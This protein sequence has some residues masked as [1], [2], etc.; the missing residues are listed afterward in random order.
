M[1]W[2]SRRSKS[3]VER[4]R[5]DWR[6][7]DEGGITRE[8]EGMVLSYSRKEKCWLTEYKKKIPTATREVLVKI[9]IGTYEKLTRNLPEM[10]ETQSGDWDKEFNTALRQLNQ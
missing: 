1:V 8:S 9:S 4:R 10:G 6:I 7:E 2:G 3:E 5:V